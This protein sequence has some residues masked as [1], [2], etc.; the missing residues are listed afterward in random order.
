MSTA[1]R[2][3]ALAD[4]EREGRRGPPSSGVRTTTSGTADHCPAVPLVPVPETL[5]SVR[6]PGARAV[7]ALVVVMPVT[8][9][10]PVPVL[11]VTATVPSRP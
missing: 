11:V 9:M 3:V 6:S 4:P 2:M 8:V 1:V 5:R 10:V 7:V